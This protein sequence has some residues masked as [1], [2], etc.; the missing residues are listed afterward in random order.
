MRIISDE[1]LAIATIWAE[2]R[3]EPRSG[4]VAVAEVIRNRTAQRK[5]SNGS[6]AS[7][8][9]WPKQFSC[10][11]DSTSWRDK[12]VSLD[13]EHPEVQEARAAWLIAT[14]QDSETVRGATLYH[15][16]TSPGPRLLWPPSWANSP[17]VHRVA[18]IGRHIFYT[19]D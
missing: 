11:N 8:I 12:I 4:Q 10:W 18:T 14:H 1:A 19:E 3:S 16:V 15:T 9:L 2:S 17:K 6:V 7:T 5:A 13:W